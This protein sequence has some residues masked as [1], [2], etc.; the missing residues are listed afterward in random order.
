MYKRQSEGTQT[1]V[2]TY[3]ISNPEKP[4]KKGCVKQDGS[5]Q[6]LSL[7]HIFLFLILVG[8]FSYKK[9]AAG[10]YDTFRDSNEQTLSLIHI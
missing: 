4:V 7:I 3:D 2:L 5:Y 10:M 6:T 8:V 9:A 1:Q